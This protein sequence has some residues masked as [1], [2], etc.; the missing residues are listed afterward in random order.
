MARTDADVVGVEQHREGRIEWR[1]RAGQPGQDEGLEEPAGM[2]QVP[3]DRTGFGH[4]LQLAVFGGEPVGQLQA[5]IPYLLIACE[6]V[7]SGGDGRPGGHALGSARK[8]PNQYSGSVHICRWV[9]PASSSSRL[10]P[11]GVYL[12]EC[13]VMM[14]SPRWNWRTAE[15]PNLTVW[16]RLAVRRISMRLLRGS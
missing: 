8:T 5:V 2:R 3:F 10:K 15:V 1:R 6:Q 16:V 11:A 4:G 14:C 13:S 9:K 12:C 7:V